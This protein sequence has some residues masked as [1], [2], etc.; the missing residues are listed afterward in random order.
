MRHKGQ[1]LPG[2]KKNYSVAVPPSAGCCCLELLQQPPGVC[3]KISPVLS[4]HQVVV[5]S[6]QMQL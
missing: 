5:M 4:D 6:E 3:K 2:V 1:V